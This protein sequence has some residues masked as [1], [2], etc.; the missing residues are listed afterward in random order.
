MRLF[1]MPL[2]LLGDKA[3]QTFKEGNLSFAEAIIEV[4]LEKHMYR[5]WSYCELESWGVAFY[6]TAGNP[7][8]PC[9]KA[10]SLAGSEAYPVRR[11]NRRSVTG[12]GG[13]A[14]RSE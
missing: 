11:R 3:E 4:A 2:L 1:R 12:S 10:L 6:H 9:G 5:T 14:V 7:S 8:L 13:Q